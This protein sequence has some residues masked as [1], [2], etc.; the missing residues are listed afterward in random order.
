M[1]RN[2][3]G[4]PPVLFFLWVDTLQVLKK[5]GNFI[6]YQFPGTSVPRTR[7]P[8]RYLLFSFHNLIK[9]EN[10][11]PKLV[12]IEGRKTVSVRGMIFPVRKHPFSRG[13][14]TFLWIWVLVSFSNQ[15]SN[16]EDVEILW[17]EIA[18]LYRSFATAKL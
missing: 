7:T 8:T 10:A 11:M 13:D 16:F 14:Y 9:I 4:I 3:R 18:F 2:E 5:S 12:G 17:W 6:W 1:T 15:F